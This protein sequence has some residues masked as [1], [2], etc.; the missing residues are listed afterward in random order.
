MSPAD[1]MESR[2]TPSASG[3]GSG[4]P[5]A[6]PLAGGAIEILRMRVLAGL[7]LS[8]AVTAFD[9]VSQRLNMSIIH[10]ALFLWMASALPARRLV[11]LATWLILL[12]YLGLLLKLQ[13]WPAELRVDIGARTL[14]RTLVAA[15]LYLLVP[16]V[17]M[18]YPAPRP[19]A[20]VTD[21]ALAQS[22]SD[23]FDELFQSLLPIATVILS[24]VFAIVVV[25]TDL[26][27][28]ANINLAIL[29]TVPLF[30]A[31]WFRNARVLWS[32]TAI[33]ILL[34]FVGYFAG[35]IAPAAPSDIG[36]HLQ[37]RVLIATVLLTVA[38][39]LHA[40][41][42]AEAVRD[43]RRSAPQPGQ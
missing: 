11:G 23:D 6:S 7:V 36:L 34:T 13:V 26:L 32:A 30:V 29:Y 3:G 5:T 12:T 19:P 37:N 9:V 33:L 35:P 39:L 25:V 10:A 17:Q 16:A 20:A 24:A 42:R 27:V 4:N 43:V 14:N 41:S 18:W 22:Q 38:L 40:V 8:I 1:V 28:P 31:S 15:I 2:A 21:D